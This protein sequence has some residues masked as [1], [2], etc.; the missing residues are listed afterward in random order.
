MLKKIN[1]I[2]ILK[3]YLLM[4]KK[5]KGDKMFNDSEDKIFNDRFDAAYQLVP[6]LEKYRNNPETIVIAI[7]R[8]GLELGYVLAKELHLPLDVV[9]TKKIGYPGNPEYAI[10]A[11][12]TEN[13]YLNEDFQNIADPEFKNYVSQ[14]INSIQS[15]LKERT[16]MYRGNKPALDLKD[17]IVIVVDDGVATGSTLIATLILIKKAKPKKIVVALPVS[18]A[19]TSEKL[20]EYC[21]ELI[22]VLIPKQFFGVGQFYKNFDQVD[23][24][25]AI[26]LLNEAN[27]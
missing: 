4:L 15:L 23:D 5:I 7:P 8:G 6:L 20:K 12:D 17:K 18:P 14:Q 16:L 3:K 9:L 22:C 10:G 13:A 26:R 27:T 2:A 1:N 11:V 21:D 24:Q 19:G 25:E